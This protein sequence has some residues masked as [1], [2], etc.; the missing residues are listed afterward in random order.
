MGYGSAQ[1]KDNEE[2]QYELHDNDFSM[3]NEL[4]AKA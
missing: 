4:L 3:G 1:A 2:I